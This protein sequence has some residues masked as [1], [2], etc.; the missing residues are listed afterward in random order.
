MSMKPVHVFVLPSQNKNNTYIESFISSLKS[1]GIDVVPLATDSLAEVVRGV[2]RLPKSDQKILHV[3]W[4]TVLY[5]SRFF[6]KSIA[7][8]ALNVAGLVLLKKRYNC[9]MVWTVH[10]FFA[11]D[12]PHPVI[13]RLGSTLVRMFSDVIIVQQQSTLQLFKEKYPTKHIEYIPHGNYVGVYGAPV[14]RNDERVR[15]LR[16]R[17]GFAD[18]DVVL[19]SF[20]AI[21]PYKHNEKIIAAVTQANKNQDTG[22]RLKF[23]VIG[24]GKPAYVQTLEGAV[25]R[26]QF[27]P[28][29]EV[30]AHM[31]L[32]DYAVFYYDD[33]EMTSGGII[34]ALSYGT[35]VIA[36]RIP[37]AE[38]VNEMNGFLFDTYE[39][40]VQILEGQSGQKRDFDRRVIIENIKNQSWS[41]SAKAL[42]HIYGKLS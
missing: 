26:N 33:S 4:P 6:I 14:D 10:N 38:N 34:L 1:E 40:F 3:Q 29:E 28:D 7:R 35:P 23:L 20:G 18:T 5:G 13:D 39:E 27:V 16:R 9:K 22:Q 17:Y 30:A 32:A 42:A 31:A 8:I 24:K 21:A 11:H 12:Y 36:R 15:E 19:M 25:V 37:G 2:C 41:N